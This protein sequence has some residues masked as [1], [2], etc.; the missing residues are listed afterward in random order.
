MNDETGDRSDIVVPKPI[1]KESSLVCKGK[2]LKVPIVDL[3]QLSI[4]NCFDYLTLM[5]VTG[6]EIKNVKARLSNA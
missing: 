6:I 2:L 4:V 1:I 5:S 3:P